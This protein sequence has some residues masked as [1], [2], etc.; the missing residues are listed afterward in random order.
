MNMERFRWIRR[1]A[2]VFLCTLS[3][4]AMAQQVAPT[5]GRGVLAGVSETLTVTAID[6]DRRLVTLRAPDGEEET[7]EVSEAARNLDQ[8]E[9]GDKLTVTYAEA[10]AVRVYPV[11]TAIKGMV[12]KTSVS[13]SPKGAK[14][15]GTI[16]RQVTLTGRVAKLDR[17]SRMVTLEGKDGSI[18]LKVAD[19]VD[20]SKV[21]E[22]DMVRIDYVE[23]LSMAV[24]SPK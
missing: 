12:A 24:E 4:G 9:K 3:M 23:T 11:T 6:H 19:D 13:R 1:V 10:L 18:T 17:D 15:Y 8:V 5:G 22:R 2:W 16:T 14:P 7:F 21:K 20:L